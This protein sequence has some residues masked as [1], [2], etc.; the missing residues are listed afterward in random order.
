[1]TIYLCTKKRNITGPE[2]NFSDCGV[3]VTLH[4]V[5][6]SNVSVV[7]CVSE[8]IFVKHIPGRKLTRM[9]VYNFNT[10]HFTQ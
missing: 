10:V 1:M 5:Y 6:L 2:E 7:L 9:V 3:Y 4:T 8:G